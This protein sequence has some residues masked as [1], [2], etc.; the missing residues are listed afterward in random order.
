MLTI[1]SMKSL[2]VGLLALCVLLASGGVGAQGSGLRISDRLAAKDGASGAS[3]QTVDYIVALVNSEPVTNIEVRRRVLRVE[4]QYANSGASLP[5]RPEL[6]RLVMEQLI[7]ERAQQQEAQAMGLRVDEATLLQ[8]EQA[9]AAQNGMGLE[10]FRERMAAEGVN[11]TRLLEELRGQILLQRVREREVQ[12]QVRVSD[13][14]VEA[15][16]SE[17]LAAQDLSPELR[18][19]HVLVLVPEGTDAQAVS[20]LQ[21]KAQSVADRARQGVDFA[22][23]AREA[24]DAPEAVQGGDFGWRS[25]QRLPELF[26]ENTQS[27]AVGEVAGPL[28]SAAGFHVLK[29]LGKRQPGLP[30]FTVTQTRARHILLRVESAADQSAAIQRMGL[31]R[32]QMAAGQASFEA[33]AREHS[34]DGS[35]REGGDLGWVGPGQFV[36]EF[37][38]VMDQ[39]APG[40]VS[41]PLVSRF[42]VHLIRVD[43]RRALQL[44]PR[45]QRA[46]LREQVQQEKAQEVLQRWAQDVRSRA[47]VEYREAPRL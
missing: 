10:A 18:L 5:D 29:V 11:R 36:P 30:E 37:E 20:T 39:L 24:S 12:S 23:L 27:L 21:A 46:L 44:E 13:A 41:D 32:Q 6:A 3:T 34:Q 31:W 14:D 43:E 26:V 25:A 47:F 38:A 7:A 22:T 1:R 40:A 15:R 4:Q 16:L 17:R 9:L 19:A 33:L 28:R 42:G 2:Y 35:A 45:E 8:A